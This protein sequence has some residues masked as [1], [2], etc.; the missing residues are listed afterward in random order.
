MRCIYTFA[1]VIMGLLLASG[2]QHIAPAPLDLATSH[3]S[4]AA[5]NLDVEQVRDYASMLLTDSGGQGAAF[6]TGDGLTMHEAQAV[7]LWYN[8][9]LRIAR[10]QADQAQAV[11]KASGRWSDPE[12]GVEMGEKRVDAEEAGF[13]HDAGSATRSWINAGSL[14]VTIPL[15]GRLGAQ[16]RFHGAEN[17]AA[18][19]RA[20]EAEWQTLSQ[21]REAWARWTFARENARLLEEH[22]S[23]LSGFSDTAGSLAQAGELPS[24]SARL[25]RIEQLRLSAEGDRAK[26]AEGEA[27]L[28]LIQLLGLMPGTPVELVP[29]LESLGTATSPP[30]PL[31]QHP[32]LRRMQAEYEV[33]E[34]RLQ[35]ELRKQYP[36]V[37]LSPTYTDEQDETSVV[38]GL[39]LP[40]PLWNANRQGIAE[41]AAEREVTRARVEAEYQR[42]SIEVAQADKALQATR[43]QLS[44]LMD[45]VIPAV[46]EQI[47]ETLALLRVGEIDVV[48][49]YETLGQALATKQEVLH[50]ALAEAIAASRVAAATASDAAAMDTKVEIKP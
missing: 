40:L 46:D 2:C 36:D 24:P 6:N 15:S 17:N 5:R 35:V 25:F 34:K 4:I 50:A 49:L 21:V 7:A 12:L 47:N 22:L 27:R 32:T 11:A 18:Q 43:A 42:L 16:K 23:L 14:S 41:A 3:E 20:A 10:L 48:V 26:S 44:Q 8:L 37:T 29:S 31:E 39:G 28:G 19:L 45:N 1:P 9:D 33:A 38:L 30:P 13:L